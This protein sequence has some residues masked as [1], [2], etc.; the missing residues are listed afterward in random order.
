MRFQP[1]LLRDSVK[2]D[3]EEAYKKMATKKQDN[4]LCPMSDVDR[5]RNELKWQAR[6][7]SVNIREAF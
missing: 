3:S 6:E 7:T 5:T 4:N 1:H 2:K